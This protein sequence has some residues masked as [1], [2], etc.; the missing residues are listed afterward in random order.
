MNMYLFALA[1]A[2]ATTLRGTTPGGQGDL[3]RSFYTGSWGDRSAL[4]HRE[5]QAFPGGLDEKRPCPV[6]LKSLKGK[7]TTA[8]SVIRYM[9]PSRDRCAQ[10]GKENVATFG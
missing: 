8:V 10:T 7:V 4:R 6:T 2:G 9:I 1:E 3:S 5:N